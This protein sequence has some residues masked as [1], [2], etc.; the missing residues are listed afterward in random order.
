[1]GLHLKDT[2]NMYTEQTYDDYLRYQEL[3]GDLVR[4]FG[5]PE[6]DDTM[7][8]CPMCG[9]HHPAED[10]TEYNGQPMCQECV[11]IERLDSVDKV[12]AKGLSALHSY[13]NP[14]KR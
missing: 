5:F 2:K 10:F 7:K 4:A 8:R 12:L 13:L 6:D 14:Y 11:D 1:M 3:V 9:D